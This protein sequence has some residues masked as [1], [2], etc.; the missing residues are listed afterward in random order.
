MPPCSI[1]FLPPAG[2]HRRGYRGFIGGEPWCPRGR[3]DPRGDECRARRPRA[4]ASLAGEARRRGGWRAVRQVVIAM[5]SRRS[6]RA[7]TRRTARRGTSRRV[8]ARRTSRRRAIARPPTR[9]TS[10]PVA[11][12]RAD[13]R[14]LA[15]RL[16]RHGI[17]LTTCRTARQSPR[18]RG[19][20]P[21]G[22][23]RCAVRH[24][25]A[26]HHGSP[27]WKPRS[28][29]RCLPAGGRADAEHA[30]MGLRPVGS[31]AERAAR[32]ARGA[33]AERRCASG[34][35]P[36][37][38]P[39]SATSRRR[40]WTTRRPGGRPPARRPVLA[41]GSAVPPRCPRTRRV[42]AAH[43]LR[44]RARAERVEALWLVRRPP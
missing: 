33:P 18:R 19:F 36:S 11:R 14:V 3:E 27:R 12:P 38:R 16:R 15:G 5:L 13:R 17:A 30:D 9:A 6:R 34:R 21:A 37:P 32:S 23:Q 4:V 39:T 35:P 44:R 2:R 31:R 28:P 42:P 41:D 40:G 43:R 20:A 8:E 29:R 25:L 22:S 24:D 7:S 10:G 1:R 26:T